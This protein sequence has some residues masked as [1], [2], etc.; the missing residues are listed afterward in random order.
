M[1]TFIHAR[2]DSTD[3][4]YFVTHEEM[5]DWQIDVWVNLR[6]QSGDDAGNLYVEHIERVDT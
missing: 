5:A 3:D 2:S 6:A 1:I 4:Y